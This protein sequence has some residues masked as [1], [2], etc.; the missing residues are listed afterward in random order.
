MASIFDILNKGRGVGIG[1]VQ[2]V[3]EMT[4]IPLI[5]GNRGDVASPS[6]LRFERTTTYGSMVF[7][8]EE[9]KPA[10]VPS[11]YMI[12]GSGAQD[13]AMSGS[14]IVKAGESKTFT[15]SCCIEETQG[16]YLSDE[17]NE[18]DVLPV[19]LRRNLVNY[20]KRTERHYGK[21][22]GSIKVWLRGLNL[23]RQTSAA[24]LRHFYDDT[25]VRSAL[26]QFAAEFEPIEG[27]IGA[28]IM[29]SGTPVGLEI[30]PTTAHWD[31]YWKQLLRGCYGSELLRLK[32][33][34]KV[35]PS[36]LILPDIPESAAP[37]DVKTILEEFMKHLQEEV[38]PLVQGITI[39]GDRSISRDGNLET[40]LIS[41][42]NGGG[43]II[44]QDSEPIY[45]SLV[46]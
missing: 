37:E 22:W 1:P 34:G 36:T 27:Q 31:A 14:G 46:L 32:M 29:F 16:G 25:S 10:I 4:V 28:V 23:S 17:G 13:H 33:L 12:R 24:H 19:E 3:D 30:M 15:S 6:S 41:T 20:E 39:Q 35:K 45:I 8:N 26:E 42:G 9:S 7:H 38:V 2:S 44:L 40:R 18:E 11:N 43:D 5:G 21:L